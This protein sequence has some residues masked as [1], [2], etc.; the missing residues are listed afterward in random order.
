[1]ILI[2]AAFDHDPSA[3]T[4]LQLLEQRGADVVMLTPAVL[5]EPSSLT[6]SGARHGRADCVLRVG[7]RTIDLRDVRSAWLWR[8]WRPDPLVERFHPLAGRPAEWRFYNGEWALFHKGLCMLL[9]QL[10]AFCVNPPPW[11][12]AFEEKC[13]QLAMAADAGL[14]IPTTLYTARPSTAR[15]LADAHGGSIV[16]KPFR[17]FVVEREVVDGQPTRVAKL[18]TNRIAAADLVE[19][20]DLLPTPGIFQP[21]VS[22]DVE[23]RIAVVGRRLFACAIH[24]Q[25]SER[26]REDWRRYDIENTPYVPYELPADVAGALL[27]LMERMGLVFGSADMIVTPEG[28]HVFLE[29]NP[30][31]QFDFMARL[32]GLPVYEHLAAMLAAA[33]P[34]Y[35]IEEVATCGSR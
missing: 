21:Y 10:G 19:T 32:A 29:V 24:S 13:A 33:T 9:S 12:V 25:L 11:N 26:S 22:K 14:A 3:R 27:R 30:N 8:G 20:D 4:V 16:Y 23:L 5:Q 6:I 2:S 7:D 28:E 15:A 1:M 18:L 34:D 31:G 35:A 17:A